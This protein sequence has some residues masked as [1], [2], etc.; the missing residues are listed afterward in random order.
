M[1][2]FV[3]AY[4]NGIPLLYVSIESS[5]R[6]IEYWR[7]V[8]DQSPPWRAELRKAGVAFGESVA[9]KTC[10]RWVFQRI[11]RKQCVKVSVDYKERTYDGVIGLDY[12]EIKCNGVNG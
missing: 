9:P 3:Y 11:V 2:G 12:N 10:S 4:P 5:V 1:A 8:S 7:L 6:L